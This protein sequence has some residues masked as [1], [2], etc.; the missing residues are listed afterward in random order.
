MQAYRAQLEKHT[1]EFLDMFRGVAAGAADSGVALTHDEVMADDCMSFHIP[2]VYRGLGRQESQTINQPHNGCSGFAAWGSATKD[3]RVICGASGDHPLAH[4]FLIAALPDTGNSYITR[5]G[6]PSFSIHPAMNNKGL[7]YVHHG[8]GSAGK[9]SSEQGISGTLLVRHTLRFTANADEALAMQLSYPSGSQAAGL[10]VDGN[11]NAFV[12]ECRNPQTVRKAGDYGE[13]DFLYAT[14]NSLVPEL[15]PY[16]NNRF[17]WDLLY[18]PHG[19]WN[20]D[21]MN[22][23][24]RNLCIWNALHNYHGK[25]D[26]DFVKMLWRFPSEPPAYPTLEEAD[27]ALYRTK[28]LGWDT[29]IGNLGNGMVGLMLPDNGD[30]GLYCACVGPAARQAEPLTAD[31]HYYHIAATHTFFELQLASRPDDIVRAAK[32]RS[33][34]DLYYAN[35]ELRK[36]TCWDVPYTPLDTIFNRAAAENQKGDYYLGIAQKT[37][38]NESMCNYAKALR[39]FTRCQAYARQV[40]ESLV[41][42]ACKPADL[43]L[44]EWFGGWGQWE[45]YPPVSK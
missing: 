40:Y 15:K 20:L 17:G 37:K 5:M 27:I 7:A 35:K 16:L 41:P 42:P 10:W 25:I 23:V 6:V 31:W 4:E 14:N 44:G 11:N 38:S 24:R 3:G 30:N 39:G 45:S 13:R 33:Q 1:P 43:G 19:G 32:K 21:D 26:L 28:G 36:L 9:E 22:S 8:A 12:L 34:Y 18:V 29:H 2:P